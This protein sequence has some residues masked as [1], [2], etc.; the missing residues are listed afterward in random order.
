MTLRVVSRTIGG[1]AVSAACA[2]YQRPLAED[3]LTTLERIAQKD[4]LR[5]GVKIRFGWSMLTLREE[6]GGLV[7]CEPDFDGDPLRDVRPRVDTTLDVLAQQTVLVRKVGV[8]PVDV[9]FE[10]FVVVAHGALD[11]RTL[12]LFRSD[13]ELDDDTGWTVSSPDQ[14]GSPEDPN[15]F[16]AIRVFVFLRRRP[17]VLSALGLPPEFAVVIDGDRIS[18][19]LGPDGRNRL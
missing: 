1:R 2:A 8:R 10:Q 12:N 19:V 14:P 17:V 9:G 13:P 7:A 5:P 18:A 3:L 16:E 6:I 4:P 15:S 11:S